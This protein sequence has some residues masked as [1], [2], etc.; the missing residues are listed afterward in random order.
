[1]AGWCCQDLI[2]LLGYAA[3]EWAVLRP[4]YIFITG[5]AVKYSNIN[6]VWPILHQFVWNKYGQTMLLEPD[7][8][9]GDEAATYSTLRR[10]LYTQLEGSISHPVMQNSRHSTRAYRY[11]CTWS[12]SRKHQVGFTSRPGLVIKLYCLQDFA[13][14]LYCLQVLRSSWVNVGFTSLLIAQEFR[15]FK[16]SKLCYIYLTG[17]HC[18]AI[19]ISYKLVQN[20]SKY[21]YITVFHGI[22]HNIVNDYTHCVRSA[23]H[24]GLSEWVSRRRLLNPQ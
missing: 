23:L 24:N 12:L 9:T 6:V 2:E 8:A 18:P 16:I 3:G 13:P 10:C 22:A 5:N 7:W 15:C 1:M 11:A 17:W 4:V 21:I 19:F 14:K 20:W